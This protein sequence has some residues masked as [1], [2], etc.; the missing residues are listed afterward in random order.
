MDELCKSLC[1]LLDLYFEGLS[2]VLTKVK[3]ARRDKGKKRGAMVAGV[4]GS[5]WVKK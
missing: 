1:A 5:S 3:T 4:F 2:K